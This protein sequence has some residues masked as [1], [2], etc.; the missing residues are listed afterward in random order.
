[1]LC[2]TGTGSKRRDFKLGAGHLCLWAQDMFGGRG[3]STESASVEDTGA[4]G[5]VCFIV[6]FIAFP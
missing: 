5:L 2:G 4:G 3:E 1:M 6:I